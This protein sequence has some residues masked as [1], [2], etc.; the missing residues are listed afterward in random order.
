MD[1]NCQAN[2]DEAEWRIDGYPK[3]SSQPASG[4]TLGG[5]YVST[6]YPRFILTLT[7]WGDYNNGK[8]VS[9]YA[10]STWQTGNSII[11]HKYFRIAGK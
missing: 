4:Y 11:E 7:M 2:A 8:R 3:H 6:R 1:F 5:S 10:A 9:C